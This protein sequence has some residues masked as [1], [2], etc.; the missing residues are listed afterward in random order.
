[1]LNFFK[2]EI[3]GIIHLIWYLIVGFLAGLVARAIMPG[4]DRMGI[5][6][7]TILGIAGSLVGG[8]VGGLIWRPQ[9]GARF[10]PAG[11]V[12]SVIGALIVLFVW[13]RLL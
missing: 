4:A 11:F 8:F 7:T 1:L 2:E 6:A 9:A 13:H 10:H 5:I 3:M 12:L